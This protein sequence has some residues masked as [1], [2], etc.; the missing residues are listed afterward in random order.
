MNRTIKQDMHNIVEGGGQG[1]TG[2]RTRGIELMLMAPPDS[3]Q[4][5]ALDAC[6][7]VLIVTTTTMLPMY[8]ELMIKMC[9]A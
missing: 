5:L 2:N 9:E 1:K 8:G 3:C 6:R 7:T 4:E